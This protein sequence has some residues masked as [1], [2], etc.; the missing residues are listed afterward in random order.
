MVSFK[1]TGF[2]KN[3]VYIQKFVLINRENLE[4]LIFLDHQVLL[5]L[6]SLVSRRPPIRIVTGHA[7]QFPHT[8]SVFNQP[9]TQARASFISVKDK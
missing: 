2:I 3:N 6:F 4:N 9:V 8:P 1:W 5:L 7:T